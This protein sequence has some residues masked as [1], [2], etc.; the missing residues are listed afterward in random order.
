MDDINLRSETVQDILTRIPHWMIRWGNS[1]FLLIILVLLMFSWIVKYPDI[2]NAEALITTAIPPQNAYAKTSGQLKAIL[3]KNNAYVQKNEALAVI[4]NTAN[5]NDVYKLQSIIDTLVIQDAPFA[6]PLDDLPVLFLGDI[7]PQ[8]A[9]FEDSYLKYQQHNTLKLYA[10]ETLANTQNISELK[11]RLK[12]LQ[13]QMQINT[14]ELQLK[15]NDLERQKTLYK[16]G[17][18]STHTYENKQL[19]YAQA[20][21]NYKNF[22]LSISQIREHIN[23]A[24][25]TSKNATINKDREGKIL[26]K[27]L[28][29]AFSQLK[30]AI[31]DWEQRYVLKSHINGYVTFLNHW[32]ENQNVNLGD[33]VFT[34]I[35]EKNTTYI[36]KLKTPALNSGKLKAGQTVLIKLENYPDNE[37]GT[38]KGEVN[39]IS[40]TPDSE[41][42]YILDVKLPKKLITSYNKEIVFK[43]EMR[44]AAEIITED[45]RLTERFLY[46]FKALFKRS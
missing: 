12:S 29:H 13:S 3:V 43:H 8:Y 18:I 28:I 38:I 44:G 21:R 23:T 11:R 17:V 6:F 16:K 24:Q 25:K 22:E 9:I 20:E 46:Q 30:K 34:I 33:L 32:N 19:E 31:R 1:L 27:T 14:T 41:G 42:L 4:E 37:F 39:R 10:N 36:A 35:P 40:Y 2:I 7:E 26:L 5:F 15:K 45:L